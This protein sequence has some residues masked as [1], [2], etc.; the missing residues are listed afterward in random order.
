MFI[1][2]IAEFEIAS[3]VRYI[4]YLNSKYGEVNGLFLVLFSNSEFEFDSYDELA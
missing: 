2:F 1:K 3:W 4:V